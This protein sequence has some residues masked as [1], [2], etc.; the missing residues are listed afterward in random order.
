M[1]VKIIVVCL[2]RSPQ[3]IISYVIL[4]IKAFFLMSACRCFYPWVINEAMYGLSLKK[5]N[6]YMNTICRN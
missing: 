4:K 1:P 6:G 5:T 2:G 3:I